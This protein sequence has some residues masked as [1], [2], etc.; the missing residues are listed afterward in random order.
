M[1]LF[2]KL[3]QEE[4]HLLSEYLA[5]YSGGTP[6]REERMDY[7]L[8]FWEEA[9]LPFYQM[10]GEQF[11]IKKE[12]MFEKP[13]SAL[14]LE[15]DE[16]FYAPLVARFID[17]YRQRVRVISK[18]DYILR[19]NLF[20]FVNSSD[21]DLVTNEYQGKSFIIPG[22]C[23][24]TGRP[25]Q[26]NQGCKLVRMLGKIT[27][28]LGI[29]VEAKVC[30]DCG[31]I[32]YD[33]T[34]FCP[35][36]GGQVKLMDGYEAFRLAHSLVLNQKVIRGNLCL[37]IHP[38]DFVTMSDNACGWSSCMSWVEEG[39]YRLGTIEMMNS[40]CVVVA[41]VEAK[42]DMSL[43]DDYK[44]NNKRWRQLLIV[45]KEIIL[46]NRQYPYTSDVLQREA[47]KWLR[48]MC[49]EVE[50][51]GP[52]SEDIH[53]IRNNTWN[54]LSEEDSV[55]FDITCDFMYNDV[56]GRDCLAYIAPSYFKGLDYY[57]LC[58]SGPAVC[59]DCGD[60]IPYDGGFDASCVQCN[61]CNGTWKCACCGDH[62]HDDYYEVNGLPY[63][64]DCFYEITDLCEI[65]DDRVTET[66]PVYIQCTNTQNEEI[67]R[68]FNYSFSVSACDDCLS[69]PSFYLD[70]FG[71]LIEVF[72][73]D[74]GCYC[75]AFDISNLSD[76][77]LR[78]LDYYGENF[79]LLQQM[80]DAKS[81][82]ERLSLIR[83]LFY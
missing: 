40:P 61:A 20:T 23:T 63:C 3:P 49:Q 58:F 36:C 39:D 24:V 33:D 18:D 81:D 60:V 52:Y 12:V 27:E 77:A 21:I 64:E 25:L 34:H 11:I 45:N 57:S 75:K 37:S 66:T 16:V 6:L 31:Q 46:G 54:T 47:M 44:W 48:E 59:T 80:R 13:T 29:K 62:F 1:S 72:N 67:I 65:C 4:V 5:F 78:C 42:D 2:E 51:W 14:A 71:P 35:F 38:M 74:W 7:F 55:E 26:V 69:R 22:S 17:V 19:N 9:K 15:M 79:I 53:R 41:Y 83:K 56:N 50:R 76:A 82:E 10:F 73:D 32:M 70:D 68:S 8:R 43:C 28:A 30:A